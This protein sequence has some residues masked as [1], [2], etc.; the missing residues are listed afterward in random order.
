MQLVVAAQPGSVLQIKHCCSEV[1][2]CCKWFKICRNGSSSTSCDATLQRAADV[3][4]L[5]AMAYMPTDSRAAGHA[6]VTAHLLRSSFANASRPLL[7]SVLMDNGAQLLV[8]AA[9]MQNMCSPGAACVSAGKCLYSTARHSMA[10]HGTAQHS[11]H[12]GELAPACIWSCALVQASPSPLQRRHGG[13][14]MRVLHAV[15]KRLRARF[16]ALESV[17]SFGWSGSAAAGG[18]VCLTSTENA[19]PVGCR[20]KCCHERTCM[21]GGTYQL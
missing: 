7:R 9:S 5:V 1:V 3:A 15:P 10:Q 4:L 13:N 6:L 18:C 11:L 2:Q 20:S 14:T 17:K 12:P 19:A 8:A 16:N 21:F